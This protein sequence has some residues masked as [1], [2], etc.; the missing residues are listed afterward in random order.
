M[1]ITNVE[2]VNNDHKIISYKDIYVEG[3]YFEDFTMKDCSACLSLEGKGRIDITRS[4]FNNIINLITTDKNGAAIYSSSATNVFINQTCFIECAA[5]HGHSFGCYGTVQSS[6]NSSAV[7]TQRLLG[8]HPTF[9]ADFKQSDVNE[10]NFTK[11]KQEILY[12]V[13]SS[14]SNVNYLACVDMEAI[15]TYILYSVSLKKCSNIVIKNVSG[16][17]SAIYAKNGNIINSLFLDSI[18][19]ATISAQSIVVNEL[20]YVNFDI[21]KKKGKATVKNSKNVSSPEVWFKRNIE[22]CFHQN[23]MCSFE[24]R[25]LPIIPAVFA[26]LFPKK[27]RL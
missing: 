4:S 10:V 14:K 7:M 18:G 23:V 9:F 5:S 16:I 1:N 27:Q 20:S 8:S 19:D 12:L 25:P 17:S 6:F 22:D 3:S 15:K 24:R 11:T 21:A 26:S 13:R 2:W